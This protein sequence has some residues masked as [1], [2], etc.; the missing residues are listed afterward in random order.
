MIDFAFA[1]A[2]PPVTVSGADGSQ[3]WAILSFLPRGYSPQGSELVKPNLNVEVARR[4]VVNGS[5]DVCVCACVCIHGLDFTVLEALHAEQRHVCGSALR[6]VAASQKLNQI[7]SCLCGLWRSLLT[8]L[9]T[10]LSSITA[11]LPLSQRSLRTQPSHH[12][13]RTTRRQQQ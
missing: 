8:P 1:L 13:P 10:N 3:A 4:S 12:A 2:P 7:Y 5:C 9:T 11:V 6:R